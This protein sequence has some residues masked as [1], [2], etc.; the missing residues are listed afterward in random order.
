MHSRIQC[1]LPCQ[2]IATILLLWSSFC[3]TRLSNP[4]ALCMLPHWKRSD[5][6]AHGIRPCSSNVISYDAKHTSSRIQ[7]KSEQLTSITNKIKAKDTYGD[8]KPIS[9]RLAPSRFQ[10]KSERA[11]HINGLERTTCTMP[12]SANLSNTRSLLR[13]LEVNDT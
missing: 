12:A 4:I 9:M 8:F 7:H 1:K 5:L 10:C 2:T 6:T 13:N 11:E 3:H